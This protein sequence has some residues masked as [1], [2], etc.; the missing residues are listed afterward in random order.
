MEDSW[1]PLQHNQVISI[2]QGYNSRYL[3][4]MTQRFWEQ[5]RVQNLKTVLKIQKA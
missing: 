5:F 4:K 2:E 1:F 3:A